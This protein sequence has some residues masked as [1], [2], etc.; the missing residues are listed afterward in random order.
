M[1]DGLIPRRYAKALLKF[2]REKG[3][4]EKVYSL[5]K[6]LSES[7]AGHPGLSAVLNNPFAPAG[8]KSEL[9]MTASG[10]A[11]GDTCFI[12][13]VKLLSLNNRVGYARGIALAYLSQYRKANNIYRVEITTAAPMEQERM[14]R[15]KELIGSHLG[16]ASVEYEV[17]VD[18]DLIGGFVVNIGSE[19]LDASLRNELKQ[20]RLK[21]LSK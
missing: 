12:D 7:F 16:G 9:L 21:L 8:S 14:N 6:T 10:A 19:R 20:L 13:F 4:A 11:S 2:A 1:N 18:T 3:Q 17:S 5:M 15:L